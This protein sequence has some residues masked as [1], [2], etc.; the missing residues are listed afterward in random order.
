MS[1]VAANNAPSEY[2]VLSKASC[3]NLI[4]SLPLENKTSCSPII[5]PFRIELKFI[6]FP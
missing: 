3:L 2:N 4:I 6:L 1:Q 5:S